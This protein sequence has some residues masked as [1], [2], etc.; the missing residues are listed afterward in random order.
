MT[1]YNYREFDLPTELL[2]FDDFP[3]ALHV[4]AK[5]PNYSLEDLGSGESREMKSLWAKNVVVIE[6]GSFT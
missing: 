3:D 2:P 1:E 5:A 6:F 4:G